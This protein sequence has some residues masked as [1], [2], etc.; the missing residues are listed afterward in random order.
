MGEGGQAPPCSSLL[1]RGSILKEIEES[2][3]KIFYISI[4]VTQ[5]F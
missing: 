1:V 2:E 5:C 3:V 4:I